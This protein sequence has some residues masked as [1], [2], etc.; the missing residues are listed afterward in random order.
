M[1]PEEDIAVMMFAV[2]RILADV[3]QRVVHPAHVP[4]VA[5]AQPAEFD[6][7]RY[8][9]PGGRL[10]RCRGRL[11]KTSVHLGVEAPQE[12]DGLDVFAAAEFVRYPAP[13][14]PAVIEIEHGSDRID[15]Q[16]VN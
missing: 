15:P 4:L 2:D 9:R 8:L 14:R 6:R 7:T 11:R 1:Q 5:E 12:V 16:T 10:L 3:I 13:G